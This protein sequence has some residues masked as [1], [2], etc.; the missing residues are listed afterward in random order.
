MLTCVPTA[1]TCV[2]TELTGAT[3][4]VTFA[5]T[6]ATSSRTAVTCGMMCVMG[7]TKLHRKSGVISTRTARTCEPTVATFVTIG[8]TS[9]M[10]GGISGTTTKGNFG[11]ALGG[12]PRNG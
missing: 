6:S 8:G 3:T 7:T 11:R 1:E 10:T 2:M 5:L 4:D 9:G 12:G